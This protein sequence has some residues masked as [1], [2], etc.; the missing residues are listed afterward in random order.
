[1]TGVE[2]FQAVGAQTQYTQS[3]QDAVR[4]EFIKGVVICTG[5]TSPKISKSGGGSGR[6]DAREN[7]IVQ[8]GIAAESAIKRTSCGAVGKGRRWKD[9]ITDASDPLADL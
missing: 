3:G 7:I 2:T 1:M 4:L 8:G 5:T 6:S 9:L